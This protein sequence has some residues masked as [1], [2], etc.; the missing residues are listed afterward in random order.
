MHQGESYRSSSSPRRNRQ[1]IQ[2]YCEH[3]P[4]PA[5]DPL[6][7]LVGGQQPPFVPSIQVL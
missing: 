7:R 3:V 6:P 5:Q 1:T 4:V 2:P